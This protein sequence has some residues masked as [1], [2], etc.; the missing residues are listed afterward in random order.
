M[1]NAG[2]AYAYLTNNSYLETAGKAPNPPLDNPARKVFLLKIEDFHRITSEMELIFPKKISDPLNTFAM[3]Y[4]Q[5]LKSLYR[6]LV[7]WNQMSSEAF[8]EMKILTLEER[9]DNLREDR[10]RAE[11]L[12]ALRHLEQAYQAVVTRQVEEKIKKYIKL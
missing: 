7:V 4:S 6:Y 3:A 8:S 12:A 5:M 10:Y 1:P 11:V 2:L 9:A